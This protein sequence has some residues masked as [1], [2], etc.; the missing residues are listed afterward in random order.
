MPKIAAEL[1]AIEVKRL[2]HP[3]G[4]DNVI[5]FVGGV[6]GLAL[7]LTPTGARSWVLRT[8][9]GAKRRN[10]GLGSYPEVSLAAARDRAREKRQMIREGVDPIQHRKE[11]R[12]AL[13]AS[14]K[15]GLSFADAVERYL[16]TKLDEF[17]SDKHK[18][19]WRSTLDSYAKPEIGSMLVQEIAIADVLRVLS[20]IWAT[21]TETAS[22]LR[23]RIEAVLSWATVAGYRTGDNPARWAGNLKELLPAPS[24]IAKLRN[25]PALALSDAASWFAN[26]RKREGTAARALEVLT[27]CACRSGEVRGATWDEFD[28]DARIWT[29]PAHR[30]KMRKEHRIPLTNRIVSLLKALPRFQDSPFVFAAPRGG[31]LSDMALSAVMRRMQESE[32]EAG[33]KGW[34]DPRSDRPAVPHG[35]RSTFRDWT[36]ECGY[37]RDMA[38]IALAHNVG[39]EAERAYRRSDMIDRRRAMMASWSD[40]LHGKATANVVPIGSL[41]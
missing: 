5:R 14:Q 4:N 17:R 37:P 3:G 36:A 2:A 26:L 21:K 30:M 28:L 23:G 31:P 39:N 13:I 34:L 20:P 1:S 41:A 16:D 38:E 6:P 40:F 10:I 24:K 8:M 27:L 25:Q 33:R 11:L 19:Q 32:V 9:V 35:L 22:R 15:R 29:I 7:Q 18:S 12:S